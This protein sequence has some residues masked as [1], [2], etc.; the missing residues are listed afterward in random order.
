MHVRMQI[1]RQSTRP[2]DY[3]DTFVTRFPHVQAQTVAIPQVIP[4]HKYCGNTCH[5][6]VFSRE[7]ASL[8]T[9][10]MSCQRMICSRSMLHPVFIKPHVHCNSQ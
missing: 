10:S 3:L 2:E 8:M 7:D 4:A 6:Q 1:N 5:Q 9:A